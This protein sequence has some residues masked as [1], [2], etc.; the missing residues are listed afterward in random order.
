MRGA[1]YAKKAIGYESSLTYLRKIRFI[2]T[3]VHEALEL[4][5]HGPLRGCSGLRAGPIFGHLLM[6]Y[7]FLEFFLSSSG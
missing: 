7:Y 1:E 5:I 6:M 3:T 2:N 4:D